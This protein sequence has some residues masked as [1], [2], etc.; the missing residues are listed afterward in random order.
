MSVSDVTEPINI[1]GEPARPRRAIATTILIT[2]LWLPIHFFAA[3]VLGLTNFDADDGVNTSSISQP[4]LVAAGSI[5][6]GLILPALAGLRA[7]KF[8][9]KGGVFLGLC[10]LGIL[11][12]VLAGWLIIWLTIT[13]W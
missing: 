11:Y 13:V 8:R 7:G 5:L 12:A 10:L 6:A 9:K 2:T 3:L 1:P 4:Q